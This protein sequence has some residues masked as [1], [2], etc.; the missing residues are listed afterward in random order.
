MTRKSIYDYLGKTI[1]NIELRDDYVY[2]TFT[3]DSVLQ[4]SL[5]Y[6]FDEK[7]LAFQEDTK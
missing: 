7:E 1:E 5:E 6:A 2:L 3:D 4:F